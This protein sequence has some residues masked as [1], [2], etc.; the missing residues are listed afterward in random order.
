MNQNIK[1]FLLLTAIFYYT[2]AQ[3]SNQSATGCVNSQNLI[4]LHSFGASSANQ[5]KLLKNAW[6]PSADEEGFFGTFGVDVEYMQ[7]LKD[8]WKPGSTVSKGGDNL[9]SVP[10]WSG[11]ANGSAT[12]SN[13]MTAGDNSGTYDLDLYQLGMGPVATSGSITLNPK[14]I[15]AG[16]D[17]SLFIGAHRTER[18]FWIK[19]HG[20]IGITKIQSNLSVSAGLENAQ[21]P[22]DTGTL[23]PL[24]MIPGA[25]SIADATPSY[26]T[27]ATPNGAVATPAPYATVAAAFAGNSSAGFLQKMTRG[28]IVDEQ[29][30]SAQ[31]GDAEFSVG[32]NVVADEKK[33][34]GVAITCSAPTSNKA[35][36]VNMLEPLFG[37]N[38]HWGA[39]GELAGH[40]RAWE[41]DD[42]DTKYFDIWMHGTG[43]HLFRSS[44]D[45]SF[46]LAKNGA[47][48]KYMLL[49]KFTGNTFQ[50]IVTNAINITT[51]KANSTFDFEGNAALSLDFHWKNFSFMIGYEGWGRTAEKLSLD[52]TP[53]STNFND[54]AVLGRQGE[55]YTVTADAAVPAGAPAPGTYSSTNS[56]LCEPLATISTSQ[57]Y[58]TAATTSILDA[59][60]ATNRISDTPTTALNVDGQRATAAY[61]SKPFAQLQYT[62]TES[63]YRPFVAL[64]GA[65]EISH[66]NNSA[67]N[68]WTVGLQGGIAF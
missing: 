54:Y 21:Q 8:F 5:I 42:S 24:V 27:D 55:G 46:D 29:T 49:G 22:Y 56:Y 36:A 20:P 51:V 4:Q 3:A 53:G 45:R 16:A 58:A 34:L 43:M 47:G 62:W 14:I 32:Y 40:W 18:G 41:S 38:G 37:R 44:H 17:F 13:T 50:N 68:F 15:Q 33:H 28:R 7:T 66:L 1:R 67:A 31:F 59:T 25:A 6:S 26:S 30:T 12:F 52:S 39:G 57:D 63:D 10:L 48:S 35:Q 23:N 61:T 60:V 65:A 9:G 64:S 19:A 11:K 2:A